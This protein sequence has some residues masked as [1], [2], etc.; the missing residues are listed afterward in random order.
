MKIYKYGLFPLLSFALFVSCTKPTPAPTQDAVT[1]TQ[2][3]T[4]KDP[5]YQ[6]P[7]TFELIPGKSLGDASLSEERTSLLRKGF[8]PNQEYAEGLYLIRDG[9]HV[10]LYGNKADLIWLERDQWKKILFKGKPLG[11]LGS[12]IDAKKIFSSCEDPVQGSGGQMVYCENRG[13]RIDTSFP[14]N[15]V[16]GFSVVLPSNYDSVVGAKGK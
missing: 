14:K 8:I 6:I 7:E 2:E 1:T 11:S 16:S 13:L 15:S 10:S 9:M 12:L 3:L 4:M 5:N